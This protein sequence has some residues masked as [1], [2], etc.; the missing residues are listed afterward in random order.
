MALKDRII[1][2]S[3]K[4]FSLKGFLGTTI[5]DILKA[6]N[7]SK[8]GFYNH[9]K[10]KEELFYEVLKEGRKIWRERNLTGL[11]QTASPLANIKLFLENFR[12]Y[13]LK[14]SENFPGGCIFI[15]LLVELKD[16][17]P[18]LA[19]EISRGFTGMKGMIRRY[20]SN[21]QD[22]GELQKDVEIEAMT[23]MIFNGMLGATITYNVDRTDNNVDTT[24]NFLISYLTNSGTSAT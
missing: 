21:A 15:T 17:R 18:H 19:K 8:G 3:L 1:V 6:S 4:L 5:D 12:D 2:E 13:Y 16:Q 22:L 24:F 14:D 11:S 7:S 20:L 9:F 23:E 10:S